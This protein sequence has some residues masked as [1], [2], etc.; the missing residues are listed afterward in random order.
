MYRAETHGIVVT[1]EPRFMAEESSH[2]QRRYFWAY[3]VEIENRGTATVQLMTRHWIITDG[4]GAVQE[5][6]GE[7]VVG[8][9]PVMRPGGRYSYSSGCP[10]TTPD[11]SMEGN[12]TMKSEDGTL[13]DVAIPL[14]ALDSPFVKKVLH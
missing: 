11:G 7:G 1:V 9:Q 6:R 3:A 2:P 12:Y 14:F 13:F 10:L 4:N 5:V 8:E